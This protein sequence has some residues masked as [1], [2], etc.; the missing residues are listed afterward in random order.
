MISL[1]G[2]MGAISFYLSR[3]E[4]TV[5]MASTTSRRE[6]LMGVATATAATG[7]LTPMPASALFGIGED[8]KQEYQD[9]TL[10]VVGEIKKVL[11]LEKD[12]PTKPEAVAALRK[13]MNGWVAK[14]RR[15]TRFSGKASYGNLYS[16]INAISGHYTNFGPKTP[17]PK[18][19]AAQI[20]TEIAAVETLVPKGR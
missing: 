9:Y 1:G 17:I 7:L 18:K 8:P 20:V 6:A 11:V 3:K 14:Y 13:E 2:I 4:D 15:D 19:R 12:D 10:K 16:V 5:A